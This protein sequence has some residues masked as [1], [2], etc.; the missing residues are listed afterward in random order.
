LVFPK[1]IAT[2]E[3]D[4]IAEKLLGYPKLAQAILDELAGRKLIED[5]RSAKAYVRGIL[6]KVDL[7]KFE[8]ELGPPVALRREKALLREVQVQRSKK[9]AIDSVAANAEAMSE[10]ES[11]A[12]IKSIFRGKKNS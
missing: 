9:A 5:V 3:R 7:G 2:W 1:G 11:I 4:A 10:K 6:E 12:A 8:P